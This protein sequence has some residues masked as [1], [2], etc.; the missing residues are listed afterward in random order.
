VGSVISAVLGLVL[1]NAVTKRQ[2]ITR[3]IS[4]QAA[5]PDG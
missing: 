1:L 4:S 2:L 3:A 5:S